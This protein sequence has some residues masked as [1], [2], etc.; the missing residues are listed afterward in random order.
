MSKFQPA[1]EDKD[2]VLWEIAQ[3]RASSKKHAFTYL[4]INAFLWGIWYF[5]GPM[6]AS[7]KEGELLS[8][9]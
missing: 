9:A 4:I 7:S 8:L 3:R 5:T 2:P 6:N 1:P